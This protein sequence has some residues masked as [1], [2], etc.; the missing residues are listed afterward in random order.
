MHISQKAFLIILIFA[1]LT[2]FFTAC[3]SS[4]QESDTADVDTTST[5]TTSEKKTII[6][7]TFPIY[8]WAREI[9]GDQNENIELILLIDTGVDLHSFQPTTADIATIADADLFIYNGGESDTWVNEVLEQPIN[10][11]LV[12]VNLMDL[13]GD[14]VKPEELVEGMQESEHAHDHSDEEHDH[15]DEEHDHSDEAAHNDEHIWLSLNNA[16]HLCTGLVPYIQA[17]DSNN[18]DAFTQNSHNYITEL[19]ALDK[20]YE[21]AVAVASRDTILV[22]DRFPFR[23]LVDDYG[24]EYYAAFEGCSAETEATFETIAFL[25]SKVDELNLS[26]IIINDGSNDDIATTVINNSQNS[27]SEIVKLHSMQ[28]IT[29]SDISNGATYLTIMKDNLETLTLVLS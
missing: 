3:S 6:A 27:S 28:S 14:S 18:S 26:N 20:E 21:N 10:D 24:I 2:S 25:S 29:S 16:I 15:S 12:A 17:L 13:L 4:N 19:S 22:A 7:T 8:D 23:Y 11:E 1:I 5:V 9:I